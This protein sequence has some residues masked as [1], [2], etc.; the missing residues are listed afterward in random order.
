MVMHI[1][2]PVKQELRCV[3]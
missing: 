3:C 2:F 1:T